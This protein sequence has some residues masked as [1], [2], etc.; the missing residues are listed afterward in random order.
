MEITETLYVK[1]SSAKRPRFAKELAKPTQ[2]E[3][4]LIKIVY[5]IN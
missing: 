5:N 4:I 2:K 3:K 1:T